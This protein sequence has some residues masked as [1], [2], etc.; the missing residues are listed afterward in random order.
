MCSR[1]PQQQGK[2]CDCSTRGSIEAS[3]DLAS[4]APQAI[5]VVLARASDA[6]NLSVSQLKQVIL[7]VTAG[8]KAGLERL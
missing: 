7:T 5:Y 3:A 4:L 1:T 6:L 8:D 2:R